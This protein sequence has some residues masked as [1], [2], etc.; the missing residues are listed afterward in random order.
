MYN[1]ELHCS[2]E[3]GSEAFWKEQ[4]KDGSYITHV[5]GTLI[6]YTHYSLLRF[7]IQHQR[8]GL[9][10]QCS[11]LRFILSPHSRGVLLTVEQGDFSTFPQAEEIYAEC[12]SGWNF[13]RDGLKATCL[14][15]Q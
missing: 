2:W 3:P 9:N 11:E 7:N 12:V 14:S 4:Q 15:V 10:G 6:E 1:C 13:V 5:Q 8:E